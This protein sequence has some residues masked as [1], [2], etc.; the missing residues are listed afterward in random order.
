VNEL[1][2]NPLLELYTVY[3]VRSLND[4][5]A[6]IIALV[7]KQHTHTH[8]HSLSLSLSLTHTHTHSHTHTHTQRAVAESGKDPHH[9]PAHTSCAPE[10]RAAARPSRQCNT[11]RSV[12][13]LSR[14]I[15]AASF[16]RC[17]SPSVVPTLPRTKR[18]TACC[19]QQELLYSLAGGWLARGPFTASLKLAMIWSN[20]S[21]HFARISSSV[22]SWI[23]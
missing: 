7:R 10:P 23:G 4:A 13:Q 9:R 6:G 5:P 21:S 17:R 12:L 20:T 14:A 1:S 8:T 15:C 11:A 19:S 3:T 18:H 16:G 2:I 22:A